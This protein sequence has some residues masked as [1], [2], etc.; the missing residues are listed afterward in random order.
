MSM[1]VHSGTLQAGKAQGVAAAPSEPEESHWRLVEARRRSQQEAELRG[2]STSLPGASS[3]F[4]APPRQEEL[5]IGLSLPSESERSSFKSQND[6]DSEKSGPVYPHLRMVG[7]TQSGLASA[8]GVVPS[9]RGS[10]RAE[11]QTPPMPATT[12]NTKAT[13]PPTAP[14]AQQQ[15]LS[16]GFVTDDSFYLPSSAQS[17]SESQD[18]GEAPPLPSSAP[19]GTSLSAPPSIPQPSSKAPPS[20][21]K[22]F[23]SAVTLPGLGQKSGKGEGVAGDGGEG[24]AGLKGRSQT[25]PLQPSLQTTSAVGLS[26]RQRIAQIER[27]LK[28]GDGTWGGRLLQLLSWCSRSMCVCVCA[29]VC[30]CVCVFC[31]MCTYAHIVVILCPSNVRGCGQGGGL[32]GGG[33]ECR[34]VP[35]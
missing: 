28:V 21:E 11:A 30:V 26:I 19:P 14:N 9:P 15:R 31:C 1:Q 3:T 12:S 17:E 22:T 5:M 7:S 8:P 34:G 23:V 10:G 33:G 13:W 2:T 4:T 29:C 16:A 35:Q 27:Q 6:T 24:A 32:G 18:D 20:T 25:M